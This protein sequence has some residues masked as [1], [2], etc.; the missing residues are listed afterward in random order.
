MNYPFKKEKNMVSLRTVGEG[1]PRMCCQ[2]LMD[3]AYVLKCWVCFDGFTAINFPLQIVMWPPTCCFAWTINLIGRSNS[4]P[5]VF[6]IF[7]FVYLNTKAARNNVFLLSEIKIHY[8]CV[9]SALF[10]NQRKVCERNRGVCF[11]SGGWVLLMAFVFSGWTTDWFR[12]FGLFCFSIHNQSSLQWL[13]D[14]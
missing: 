2:K 10:F 14:Y 8:D 7:H 13:D 4:L 3:F 6:F 1:F 12:W 11:L 9:Y 5:Y